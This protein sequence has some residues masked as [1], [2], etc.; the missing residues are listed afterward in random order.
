MDRKGGLKT[1]KKKGGGRGAETG[2]SIW[3][4]VRGK[5]EVIP[6]PQGKGIIK[7][8]ERGPGGRSLEVSGA[9]KK[10]HFHS[11]A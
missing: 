11:G 3:N 7:W 10:S 1:V 9:L 5:G 4:E 6:K 8:A 2:A